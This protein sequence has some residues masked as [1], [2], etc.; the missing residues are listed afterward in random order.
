MSRSGMCISKR[1]C[2]QITS[3]HDDAKD[4][5]YFGSLLNNRLFLIFCEI[6][7]NFTYRK[8]VDAPAAIVDFGCI[9]E[10]LDKGVHFCLVFDFSC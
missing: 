4:C 8:G 6:L 9:F 10:F 1:S 7:K 5:D 2:N 3:A